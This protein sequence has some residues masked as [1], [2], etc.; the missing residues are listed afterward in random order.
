MR[1]PIRLGAL[2]AGGLLVVAVFAATSLATPVGDPPA[3]S[4]NR[5]IVM[6]LKTHRVFANFRLGA[7]GMTSIGATRPITRSATVVPLVGRAIGSDGTR[8]LQVLL[9]GR[10]N[11]RTGWIV[12]H[13]TQ[14]ATTSWHVVVKT[15]TRT[16]LVY[17]R[18]GLVRSFSAIVG[19]PSTPT[20]HGRF[21][22]EESVLMPRGSAG[23]PFA[24]A[25]NAHSDALRRFGGGAGQIALHGVANLSG[26]LGTASSH[27]CVR[28]AGQSI[29]WLADH[30]A[31]GTPVTITA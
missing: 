31:A 25:L 12:Q 2:A 26:T 1:P 18:G 30:I 24:L 6:L 19:K 11:G 7:S 15:S 16:V 14:L 9:P 21:F 8:W 27:G 28:L 20:P 10:P 22:V 17:R 3:V 4:P 13:Q 29:R 23:A 5:E